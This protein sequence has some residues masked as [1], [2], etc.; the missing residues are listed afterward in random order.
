LFRCFFNSCDGIFLNYTWTDSGLIKSAIDADKQNRIRDI[1]VGLDVWGRGCPGG[2]G[3]N[4][5]YV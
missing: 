3:F 1:Y 2:G 4:S 5:A